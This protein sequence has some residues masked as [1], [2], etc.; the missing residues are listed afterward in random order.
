MKT[1]VEYLDIAKKRYGS[2]YKTA[3][4]LGV[5]HQ[6]IGIW[7]KG[8]SIKE[9]NLIALADYIDVPFE[10]VLASYHFHRTSSPLARA[11]WKRLGKSVAACLIAAVSTSYALKSSHAVA[12]EEQL[13]VI[14]QGSHY[15]K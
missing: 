14:L 2:D 5:S 15:T 10:A 12:G 9:D 13:N 8:G 6:A 3:K 1:I 7:R 11:A 4:A